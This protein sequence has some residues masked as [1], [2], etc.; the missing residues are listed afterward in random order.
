MSLLDSLN[1]GASG[2]RAASAGLAA[3]TQNV[4]NV[5][6]EGFSRRRVEQSTADPIRRGIAWIGQGAKTLGVSRAADGL[7]MARLLRSTGQASADAAHGSALSA[8]EAVFEPSD[9]RSIRQAMDGFFDALSAATADPSDLG[10]R[11]DVVTSASALAENANRTSGMLQTG[12]AERDEALTASVDQVN[13]DLSE[14]AALNEQILRGGGTFGAADL[15]D[16]RDL[17]M[18]RLAG[19]IGA[20]AHVE[21]DGTMTVLVGGHAAVSRLEA[22]EIGVQLNPGAAPSITL[23]V[24][25]GRLDVTGDVTGAM[26]GELSARASL[27][28]W[29]DELDGMMTAFANAVNTQHQAGFTASGA[30]GGA[31]FVLPGSGPAA[32]GIAVDPAILADPA[33]LAFAGSGSGLPGDDGNLRALMDLESAALVGGRTVG[34]AA[35]D[36][37]SRVGSETSLASIQADASAAMQMDAEELRSHLSSVDLDE[38][39]VNLIQFQTAYAAAAKVVVAADEM[40]QTLLSIGR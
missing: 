36:L 11:R 12:I 8:F 28:S 13:A 16:R 35:S 21:A 22:R 2:L 7:A 10:L 30:S 37:T 23:S 39:A 29:S 32:G 1:T 4:A 25:Q 15:M 3:T 17:A 33:N 24:D 20:T 9:G 26:G 31:L 27:Q 19:S 34:Q 40:L 5:S 6:T 14:I 38:E 18:T